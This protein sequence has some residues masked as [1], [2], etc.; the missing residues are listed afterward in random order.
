LPG[1]YPII[2]GLP[3]FLVSFG[4]RSFSKNELKCF[5]WS[6]H[7]S[8]VPYNPNKHRWHKY[9]K[10][11]VLLW[12]QADLFSSYSTEKIRRLHIDS[13]RIIVTQFAVLHQCT[14]GVTELDNVCVCMTH[15]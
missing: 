3:I 2:E 11:L 6:F 13:F 8:D 1:Y 14:I 9:L 5:I 4:S 7:D 12:L 15:I 10:S